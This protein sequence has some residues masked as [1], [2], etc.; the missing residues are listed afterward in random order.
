M[1]GIK[2][3]IVDSIISLLNFN[4][5]SLMFIV[6]VRDVITSSSWKREDINMLTGNGN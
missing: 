1:A 3:R 5:K 6:N 2:L 4:V